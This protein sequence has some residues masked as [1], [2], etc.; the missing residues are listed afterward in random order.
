MGSLKNLELT[1]FL[2]K[3][4]L[5]FLKLFCLLKKLLPTCLGRL[6]CQRKLISLKDKK[7][8]DY[9]SYFK[10][11]K[12]K[13]WLSLSRISYLSRMFKKS[14]PPYLVLS[15]KML[16]KHTYLKNWITLCL[17]LKLLENIPQN[18]YDCLFK[19]FLS[20]F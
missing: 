15:D 5:N 8:L 4:C 18:F 17:F 2:L 14:P 16:K 7:N 9:N 1:V 20:F 11:K 12:K 19:Q 13:C 10:T 6:V 3:I